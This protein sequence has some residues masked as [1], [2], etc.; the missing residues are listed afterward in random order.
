MLVDLHTHTLASDGELSPQ[1]MLALQA[2][3]GTKLTA[4]TDN[5]TRGG[6][7]QACAGAAGAEDGPRLISALKF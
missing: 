6:W 4:F 5:D 7:D 3:E 2:A 1:A